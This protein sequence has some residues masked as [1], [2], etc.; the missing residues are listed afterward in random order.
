MSLIELLAIS[1]A[2]VFLGWLYTIL[3]RDIVVFAGLIFRRIF[4]RKNGS[5]KRHRRAE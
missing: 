5:E 3:G 1:V 4:G 2:L